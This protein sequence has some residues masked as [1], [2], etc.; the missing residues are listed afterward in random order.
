MKEDGL[1]IK[2]IREQA[3]RSLGVMDRQ[4][5]DLVLD[6][7]CSQAELDS[8]IKG[9]D[10]EVAPIRNI[11]LLAHLMKRRQDLVFPE[12]VAPRLNGVLSYCR[13]KE[14]Q[15]RASLS[16]ISSVLKE[17]NLQFVLAGDMAMRG[18][19][20]SYQRWVGGLDIIVPPSE[21]DLASETLSTF[22]KD[23]QV[24][25]HKVWDSGVFRRANEHLPCPEDMVF[26]AL[27]D[28]YETIIRKGGLGDNLNLI[29]D[30]K[31]L[32]ELEGGLDQEIIWE[33][34]R[35]AGAE[36][37]FFFAENVVGTVLDGVFAGNYPAS[38]LSEKQLERKYIDFLFKKDILYGAGGS[39]SSCRRFWTSV[40]TAGSNKGLVPSALK[41]CIWRRYILRYQE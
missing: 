1:L 36:F 41:K 20:P 26:M 23:K 19:F 35:S 29:M 25:I 27:V 16:N 34:A 30:I 24:S 4:L 14:M 7:T 10:I 18:Y 37:Q 3:A 12:T 9:W 21:Y 38:F 39:G 28:V 33:N 22:V 15:T 11:V 8:F 32:A 40:L 13:F 2:N 6:E 17:K 31:Q 5:L